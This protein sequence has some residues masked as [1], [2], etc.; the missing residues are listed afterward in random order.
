M[1]Q[2]LK[3][4]QEDL[5]DT[6]RDHAYDMQSQ[7]FD[8]LSEDL[9]TSLDDTEYEI[10]HNADKQLEII[11]SML[12]K[13]VSSYQE[14]YGKI[15][16]NGIEESTFQ[17]TSKFNNTFELTFDLNENILIQD[18]KGLSKLVHSNVYD[19]VGWLMRVYVEN[20]GWFIMEHPKITDDGMKQT[21]TI[22]CQSAEIEMQ[23]HDLKNFKINQGTT[24]SY[25]MLADNNVEKIDDVEFAKE[26]I[27]FHNPKNPQLSLID[28]ALKASGMKGWSVGEIDS[29]PKTY[30]T[31]KDGKYVETTTLLSNEI[32]A[33]DI[34][35]QD[36]YSF[37][38]QDMAKYFQ[39]VF[40]FDFLHMKISAYHP[41]N[42]G[43]S[44]NVNINFRNLQQSQEISVD[45]SNMYTRYYVQGADDLGIT[46][47]NFG[48]NYIENIDYYLNEKY[49]S[50]LLIIKL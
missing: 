13:A 29:T 5:D 22:T 21:K 7:G 16:S 28:L 33:F 26:Q 35:S 27:K 36:L 40:V 11:N 12:D 47:V 34:E 14:A 38:T 17:L 43:K 48:S 44:T 15:N 49:F 46:Y 39:C 10:S 37:F 19:L 18:G 23:Q 20:V 30:R 25:E 50:P 9:K 4:A 6:K 1:K 24:D 3:E 32:G 45:D 2:Q 42:Y 31:Y 8:K 41:E